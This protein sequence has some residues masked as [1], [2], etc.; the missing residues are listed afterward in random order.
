MN[1]GIGPFPH[2]RVEGGG[3]GVVSQASA[4]LLVET[5]RRAG[6][7]GA[8]SAALAPGRK[9]RAVHDPG[10]VLPDVALAV[11]LG[12]D[13]LADVGMLR[14]EPA[15][16][17]P[18]VSRLIAPLAAAGPRAL[19][20]TW[21]ARAEVREQIWRLTR[22]HAAD[23]SGALIADI[24]ALLVLA[25]SQKQDATATWKN[26]FVH[27]PLLAF[28]GTGREGPPWRAGC[29]PAAAGPSRQQPRRGPH[30]SRPP[31]PCPAAEAAPARTPHAPPYRLRRGT[32]EFLNWLTLRGQ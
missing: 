26:T 28:A 12:G 30:R 14:A 9:T 21:P 6:L 32:H 7:H 25:H 5:A 8:I 20:A 3:R 16:S 31:G 18:T 2:V 17:G 23:Q 1:K 13:C 11:A 29:R 24:D 27:Q 19:T 15:V 4:A 10:K 22:Q